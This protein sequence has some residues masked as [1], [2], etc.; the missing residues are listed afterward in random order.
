MAGVRFFIYG[1]LGST[2]PGPKKLSR[3]IIFVRSR[4]PMNFLEGG[5]GVARLME[6]SPKPIKMSKISNFLP[7]AS[8]NS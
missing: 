4:N 3:K 1:F 7:A 8:I 6:K 2:D 5:T